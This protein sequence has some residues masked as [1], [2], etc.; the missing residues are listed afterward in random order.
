MQLQLTCG[1]FEQTGHGQSAFVQA[2]LVGQIAT[3]C[4]V[5]RCFRTTDLCL[6]T[7]HTA[8]G[9]ATGAHIHT[10]LM[11][12][13]QI[14]ITGDLTTGQ[15][16]QKQLGQHNRQVC[17]AG[18]GQLIAQNA[19]RQAGCQAV[20]LTQL[21]MTAHIQRIQS[22]LCN[23]GIQAK[24]HADDLIQKFSGA[25]GDLGL[26]LSFH[27]LIFCR[28]CIKGL[29]FYDQLRHVEGKHFRS[30]LTAQQ[31][32]IKIRSSNTI[33][34]MS[35]EADP[36]M[37]QAG[38]ST[39]SLCQG[40]QL[41]FFAV[42]FVQIRKEFALDPH[43]LQAALQ[44]C[45]SRCRGHLCSAIVVG[46]FTDAPH[47]QRHTKELSCCHSC[48]TRLRPGSSKQHRKVVAIGIILL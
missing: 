24:A 35:K 30:Q 22:K 13:P 28:F 1:V 39:G 25:T 4:A 20:G 34:I 32:Q 17:F 42:A 5:F 11:E 33:K 2:G 16:R 45:S 40:N 41:F 23:I 10:I 37:A 29:H 38:N 26:N 31:T 46:K 36:G 27:G 7:G 19:Q 44:G 18:A 47:S 12:G 8:R 21:R 3:G 43:F 14:H 15:Q 6:S 48:Q 9:I